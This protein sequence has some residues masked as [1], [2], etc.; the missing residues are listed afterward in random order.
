M[1]A[2]VSGDNAMMALGL[3]LAGLA[4]LL[5]FSAKY[6]W[7]RP[8]VA[9]QHPRILMYHMVRDPIAGAQFNGLRVSPL[10][11]EQQLAWLR[12]NGFEF[13]FLSDL[14]AADTVPPSVVVI[15][16]DDGYADNFSNAFPL[17]Q[18]YGAK[19]TLF[20]VEQRFDNDWSSKKKSHHDSGEL[21][22]EPKLSDAQV[23]EM[24]DSGAVEIGG[25]SLTHADFSK[26]DVA[27]RRHELAESRALQQQ[28][29]AV[30]VD[31]Y[32]YTFGIYDAQDVALV[33]EL[34]YRAAVTTAEGIST[35][36]QAE[37]YTLRRVKVSGRKDFTHFKLSLR[38][39]PGVLWQ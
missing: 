10:A 28:K 8:A 27:A 15:T 24:I 31:T 23:Q 22:R 32:A 33:Q 9:L 5:W 4:L 30:P 29:F 37:R 14:M 19:A 38:L 39:G 18:K 13:W 17:L 34:G 25:H 20:L 21:M 36:L 1:G 2:A 11:F 16:F 26:L 6:A 7:W 12:D 35:D 3:L